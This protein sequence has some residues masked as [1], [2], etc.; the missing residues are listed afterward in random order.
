MRIG[1]V[2]GTT[3][4]SNSS[5]SMQDKL[6][7]MSRFGPRY[8]ANAC[9]LH[10][11]LATCRPNPTLHP[12]VVGGAEVCVGG[13]EGLPP[14]VGVHLLRAFMNSRMTRPASGDAYTLQ[15]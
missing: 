5:S 14:T 8:E 12:S 15:G 2:I 13:G 7:D 9:T 10:G 1:V 11:C 4:S 6:N 3:H